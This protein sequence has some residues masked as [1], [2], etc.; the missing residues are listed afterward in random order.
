MPELAPQQNA[1]TQMYYDY[2]YG[3]YYPS[4]SYSY[5][6]ST[7]YGYS[8]YTYHYDCFT[9]SDCSSS[10][11]CCAMDVVSYNDNFSST[12]DGYQF[13]CGYSYECSTLANANLAIT[14]GEKIEA[15]HGFSN[16]TVGLLSAAALVSVIAVAK[17]CR[18]S[19]DSYHK[20]PLVPSAVQMA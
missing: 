18:R 6:Y 16:A 2:T 20:T 17:K 8:S 12:W 10:Q 9:D 15:N 13:S 11:E 4:S 1:A 5:S 3:D 19:K 7:S 14:A